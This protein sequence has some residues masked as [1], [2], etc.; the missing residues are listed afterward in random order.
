MNSPNVPR[1]AYTDAP[2]QHPNLI[3]GSLQLLFWLF[4]RP[5]A[6]RNHVERIRSRG[7]W[8]NQAWWR[9]LVQGCLILTSLTYLLIIL[10][11]WAL[12]E[13]VE[14]LVFNLALEV[15]FGV[16]FVAVL[17]VGW[18]MAIV[19]MG[20]DVNSGLAWIAVFTRA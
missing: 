7:L 20:A 15:A 5:T 4:F 10:V 13:S 3:L 17:G 18:G 14:Y 2:E 11:L 8:R 12:D 16:A 9:L 19:I 1:N 6:W